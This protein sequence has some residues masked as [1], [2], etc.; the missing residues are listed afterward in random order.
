MAVA[1]A[2]DDDRDASWIRELGAEVTRQ[3]AR[4]H[5]SAAMSD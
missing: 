3:D 5:P 2:A 1:D 4:T